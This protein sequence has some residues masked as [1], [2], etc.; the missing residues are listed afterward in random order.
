MPEE[1]PDLVFS[2]NFFEHLPTKPAL[3]ATLAQAYR[4]LKKGGR[5]IA[6]GPNIR[7]LP[8]AY[9][10]FWDH[11]IPLTEAS[12]REL[13]RLQGVG[14]EGCWP[15]FLPYTISGGRRF[16]IAALRLYLRLRPMWLVFGRQFL[17][18]VRKP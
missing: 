11:H 1:S 17:L 4:S 7:F 5:L 2:S 8:G 12:L 14:V 3:E 13:L 6:M 18:I 10:D 9:W 15:R 16:P